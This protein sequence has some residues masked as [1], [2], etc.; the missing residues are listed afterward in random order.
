MEEEMQKRAK[1]L[2][3]VTLVLMVALLVTTLPAMAQGPAP[4]GKTA[5]DPLTSLKCDWIPIDPAPKAGY[6][7]DVYYQVPYTQGT[8]LTIYANTTTTQGFGFDVYTP[9]QA[10]L[11]YLPA[12]NTGEDAL[13]PAATMIGQGTKSGSFAPGDLSWTGK[14]FDGSQNGWVLVDVWNA[15]ST[16][17]WYKLCSMVQ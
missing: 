7:T 2:L 9:D 3:L 5:G 14:M 16:A 8:L 17:V 1:S 11:Y 10:A 15:N 6:F 12:G 4:T 13:F